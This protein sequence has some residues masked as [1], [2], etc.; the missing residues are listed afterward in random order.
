MARILYIEDNEQ[1]LYLVTF[2]LEKAGHQ[3][4]QARDGWAGL[5]LAESAAPD[6]VL[7][8][9]QLPGMDGMEVLRRLKAS[10]FTREIP[11]LAVTSYAMVGDRERLLQAGCSGYIEK[12]INPETFL[13]QVERFLSA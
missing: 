11:V 12:P 5:D 2:I 6:M 1:N 13:Q 4:I 3:V 9:F 8:D 10:P 7:L